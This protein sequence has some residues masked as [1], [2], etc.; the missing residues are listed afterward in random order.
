MKIVDGNLLDATEKYIAHQVNCCGVMGAGVARAIRNKWPQVFEDY[1]RVCNKHTHAHL[2]GKTLAAP[3]KDKVILN[4]FG[5][6]NYG[7]NGRYTIYAALKQCF[8]N[9]A[10]RYTDDNI[11]IP[12]GIGCGLAGGDWNIVSKIIENTLGDRA[13]VYKLNKKK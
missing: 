10:K 3:A 11:A 8:E 1:H 12:Y 4:L 9:I 6:I 2:I 7:N 5:Q 13:I